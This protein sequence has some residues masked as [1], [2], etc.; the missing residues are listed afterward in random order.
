MKRLFIF[1][2]ILSTNWAAAQTSALP[3]W[4]PGEGYWVAESNKANKYQATVYFYNNDNQLIYKETIVHRSFNLAKRRTL[5]HLRS[6]LDTAIA[7]HRNGKLAEAQMPML[8]HRF[9]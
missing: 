7:L 5:M 9:K 3:K 6:V 2:L 4:L 1:I 8:A